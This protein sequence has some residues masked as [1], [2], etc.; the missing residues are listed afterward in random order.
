MALEYIRQSAE[1]GYPEAL[2]ELGH[3]YETGGLA[4]EKSGKFHKLTKISLEKAK[5]LYLEASDRG[6]ELAQNYLGSYFFNHEDNLKLAVKYFKLAAEKGTSGRALNNL[7]ICYELGSLGYK[8]QHPAADDDTLDTEKDLNHAAELYY[9]AIKLQ[10]LPAMTNLA[11]LLYQCAR[12]KTSLSY[13]PHKFLST[14]EEPFIEEEI[15]D[16]FFE[17]VSLLRLALF[18]DENLADANFLMGL[19][20]EN[21]LSIDRNHENAFKY[22]EKAAQAGHAKAWVKLGHFWYSG[23][24]RLEYLTETSVSP[25]SGQN[26]NYLFARLPDKFEAVYCYTQAV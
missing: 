5:E 4:D 21:G 20:F 23:V 13:G 2:T 16:M 7:A 24:R 6:C 8:L 19:M 26:S 12:N 18:Q 11:Y 15:D 10:H 9:K 3:V 1:S 22:F 25:I 14:L 17:A